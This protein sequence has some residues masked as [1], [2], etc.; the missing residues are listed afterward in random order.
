MDIS[1]KMLYDKF[2]LFCELVGKEFVEEILEFKNG[3]VEGKDLL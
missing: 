1:N 3:K 2:S